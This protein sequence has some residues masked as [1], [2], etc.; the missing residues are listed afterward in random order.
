MYPINEFPY[1]AEEI[2]AFRFSMNSF[3][4]LLK[5]Q[6]VI[7]YTC[8]EPALFRYWLESNQIRD[9][10]NSSVR[11]IKAT[12]HHRRSGEWLKQVLLMAMLPLRNSVTDYLSRPISPKMH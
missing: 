8:H 4:I 7:H 1:A 2:S 10:D 9:V 5:S 12:K 11:V 6:K 3:V